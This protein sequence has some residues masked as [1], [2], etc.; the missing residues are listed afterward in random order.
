M[1]NPLQESHAPQEFAASEQ[2]IE[3]TSKISS[4]EKLADIIESDLSALDPDKLPSDWRDAI[5]EGQLSFGF[6][7]AKGNVPA[8]T[9]AV[10]VTVDA[11]C[12]RCLQP[13]T[14]PLQTELRLQF[15]GEHSG[16]GDEYEVW[17]LGSKELCP[18]DLIEE[19]LI[20]TIPL[21]AMHNDDSNCVKVDVSEN[22]VEKMALPFASL[23]TQMDKEN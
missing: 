22:E 12:Q 9:G 19:A 14:L 5:V 11:V 8:L 2:V 10:A 18:A 20:M 6:V 13:F 15:G 17:E 23:K 7:G 21:V 3:I 16:A 4:F 1:V